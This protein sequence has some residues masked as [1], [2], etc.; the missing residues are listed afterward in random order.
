MR[1]TLA[2]ALPVFE[3]IGAT[4]EAEHPD[5][6]DAAAIFPPLRAAGYVAK[7]GRAGRSGIATR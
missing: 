6:C 1:E 2:A 5:L 4:V 3:A 7:P